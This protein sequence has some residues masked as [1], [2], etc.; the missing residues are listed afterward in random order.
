MREIT[1]II[2]K[3]KEVQ[4]KDQSELEVKVR[5]M[6]NCRVK[7]FGNMTTL[8]KEM[9]DMYGILGKSGRIHSNRSRISSV[10]Q[11]N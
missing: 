2:S 4:E 8:E 10:D 6:K 1:R 5:E 9:E 3:N 7:H 11:V